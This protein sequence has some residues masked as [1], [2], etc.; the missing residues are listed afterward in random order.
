[1]K[2]F[3][4]T[5]ISRAVLLLCQAVVV[6]SVSQ[7]AIAQDA[8]V[9]ASS[10]ASTADASDETKL[11][12]IIISQKKISR[13][14]VTLGGN[15]IQK[16]LPG[17]NPLKA[18]QTLPGVLYTTA[19]PWG[20][21]EQNAQLFVHGFSQQQLGY[22]LD[23]VPLGDQQYGN[24]NGLSPQRAIIS[25]NLGSVTLASGAGSLS[26]ASTSNLGGTITMQSADP[27]KQAGWMLEEVL[28]SSDTQRTFVRFDTGTFGDGNAVALSVLNQRARAWD[29]DGI[30]GGPQVNLKW[31]NTSNSGKFTFFADYAKKIEPN[32][33]SI[34]VTTATQNT[35]LPYTRPFLYPDWAAGLSYLNPV[36]G[37]PPASAGSNFSNYYSAAQRR[38][39]LTYLKYQ[40]QI[41]DNS[42]WTNQFY[43]HNNRGAGL[44]AGPI[45]Q[46]GLP[47]LFTPYYP[48]QDLKTVFGGSGYALRTTEY[49]I[50]RQGLI[51]NAEWQIGNHEIGLGVW[52]EHSNASQYR[53]WY[54][55]SVAN[56]GSP[57][58]MPTNP[59]ITQYGFNS[60]VDIFQPYIQD[61][62][63]ARTDL[64]LTGGLKL[65]Y[66]KGS[67]VF[68]VQP[69]PGS[70]SG[71]SA[72]GQGAIDTSLGVLPQFGAVWTLN[73]QDE[74]FAN[75]QKNARQ[76]IV[77]GAGGSPWSLGSQAAFEYF[78][79]NTSPE[80]AWTYELGMRFN[81]ALNAGALTGVEGQINVYHVDFSNRLLSIS[82]TS[83]VNALVGGAAI[84]Q[85]VGGVTTDGLDLAVTLRFGQNFSFY[86]ALSY[87]RSTYNDDYTNGSSLVSTGGKNVPGLANWMDR[88]VAS[89]KFGNFEAQVTGDYIGERFATYTNDLSVGSSFQL[90]LQ[91]SYR[92]D[93]LWDRRLRDAKISLNVMNLANTT[94][95]SSL[96]VGQASGSYAFYPIAPR[97]VF[98]NFTTRL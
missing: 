55:V 15:E 78:K 40:W 53:N 52:L 24:W 71:V 72:F 39:F 35:A 68:P 62:W 65:S 18:I 82:P 2:V 23:G 86:N 32:E 56:A 26:T 96:A 69:L 88:F 30:Q 12:S 31:T 91:G 49:T 4:T 28:G 17:I 89:A 41:D 87:N 8:A 6:G 54:P 79:N 9:S 10:S 20:N 94:G 81:R 73:K 85:N 42:S 34:N 36:T 38:D 11:D 95:V 44:V 43:L 5:Q 92:W 75:V 13:S 51:S 22:T 1:M 76:F 59:L 98:V 58:D 80:S 83:V 25:E 27:S 97:Q 61:Q 50:D 3:S 14:A 33:D 29:F 93:S 19:D 90:G 47:T 77:Y 21:N 70:T 46:A 67:G 64:I 16:V 57:Y 63:K 45:N 74:V 84:I 48:G 66:Q 60:T 37:A 7:H